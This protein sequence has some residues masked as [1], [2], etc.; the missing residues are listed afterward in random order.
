MKSYLLNDLLL[1]SSYYNFIIAI[2]RIDTKSFEEIN[3]MIRN[4]DSD[5]RCY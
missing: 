2:R 5:F 1:K 4:D 3:K